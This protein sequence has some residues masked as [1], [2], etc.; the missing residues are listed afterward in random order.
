MPFA[1]PDRV[2][3]VHPEVWES[4][5]QDPWTDR[6][7]D[8][9]VILGPRTLSARLKIRGG[10]TRGYPKPSYELR[11]AN[12]HTFHWNAEYDDPSLIRNALS[13]YFF[14]MVGLP[15]PKTTHCRLVVNGRP[16]GVYL[17]LEAVVPAFFRARR[18][19]CRSIVYAVNDN[20]HFGTNFPNGNG[21]KRSL[22]AGYEK[23]AG[24]SGTERRLESFIRELNRLE[25]PALKRFLAAKLD[26]G[27]Y[28]KWLAGAVLTGNYDGFEQNY[29]LYEHLP[30][31]KYRIVP[32]DYEG[33]WG[34]NCYGQISPVDQV[35][36]QGYNKLTAKL[37]SFPEYRNA[38]RRLLLRLLRN[39]FTTRKL[40]P[41]A[42]RMIRTIGPAV[43]SD[44][45]RKHDYREFQREPAVIRQYI[46]DRRAVVIGVLRRWAPANLV[47]RNAK[48]K[49]GRRLGRKAN[50]AG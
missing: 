23:V 20:A 41:V 39:A 8:V 13:F 34:R 26:I 10:H 30:S 36:V 4:L 14:N 5:H 50:A 43:R 15:A 9:R 42:R 32:W 38:Y 49:A 31:G 24:D 25:G 35:R 29:A 48:M 1:I 47:R 33:T 37:L 22:F 2:V 6:T 45:S 16:L 18:I 7:A 3:T 40:M 11:I 46:R 44:D 27:C 17:E 12:G 28:L 19:R 21:P